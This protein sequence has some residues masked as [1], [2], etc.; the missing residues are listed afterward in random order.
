MI[1]IFI[2]LSIIIIFIGCIIGRAKAKEENKTKKIFKLLGL[3]VGSLL[4]A[5]FVSVLFFYWAFGA[6]RDS[7]PVVK[8]NFYLHKTGATREY[9]VTPRFK[10]WLAGA[11]GDYELT[12]YL[13][14]NPP[15]VRESI[16]IHPIV[17]VSTL[18]NGIQLD[19]VTIDRPFEVIIDERY[20]KKVLL[21]KLPKVLWKGKSKSYTIK[22]EVLQGD[23]SLLPYSNNFDTRIAVDN[24]P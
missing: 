11:N 22:V 9:I 20:S 17:K 16:K 15:S 2:V 19:S 5:G 14:K 7:R 13:K 3:I 24:Y 10:D 6:F 12:V 21:T 1:T 4:L 8:D 18:L 23:E